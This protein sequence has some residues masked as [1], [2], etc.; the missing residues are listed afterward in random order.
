MQST[1]NVHTVVNVPTVYPEGCTPG[2]WPLRRVVTPT[3]TE[4][5]SVDPDLVLMTRWSMFTDTA[6]SWCR[7]N[8]RP[9][10]QVL[11]LSLGTPLKH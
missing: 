2:A 3:D 9:T 8:P 1:Y 6:L 7:S 10:P 11:V 5:L 4:P